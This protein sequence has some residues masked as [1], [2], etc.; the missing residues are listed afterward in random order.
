[1]THSNEQDALLRRRAD[2]NDARLGRGH[3]PRRRCRAGLDLPLV[4]AL[5]LLTSCGA[6]ESQPTGLSANSPAAAST[7]SA[8]SEIA[9]RPTGSNV[10]SA[11]A[12]TST[13]TVAS[14]A[15]EGESDA[16][17]VKR[18]VVE[19]LSRPIAP[20]ELLVNGPSPLTPSTCQMWSV[21]DLT[22]LDSSPTPVVM[23]DHAALVVGG[24]DDK[25][26]TVAK[27]CFIDEGVVPPADVA[28]DL[29]VGLSSSVPWLTLVYDT[30]PTGPV[31][32]AATPWQAPAVEPIANGFVV[33]FSGSSVVHRDGFH[34]TATLTSQG[35]ADVVVDYL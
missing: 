17:L 29:I 31:G 32:T 22:I 27:R 30:A 9:D 21:N 1:M 18:L 14:S 11:T 7:A 33:T 3:H 15:A 20:D 8:T 25:L 16:D 35:P 19:H 5:A 10:G 4:T 24:G 2:V 12:T 26:G 23:L 34:V 13:T 28:V 6:S